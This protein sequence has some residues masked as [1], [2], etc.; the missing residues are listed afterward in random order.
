[1]VTLFRLQENTDEGS[2]ERDHRLIGWWGVALAATG[3][4]LLV[5][6]VLSFVPG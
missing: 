4:S 1:V 5:I 3:L 6:T 2:I